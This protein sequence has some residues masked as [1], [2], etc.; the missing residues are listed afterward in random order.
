MIN[1]LQEWQPFYYD[2][3][4]SKKQ[5]CLMQKNRQNYSS[6]VNTWFAS[7]PKVPKSPAEKFEKY[8]VALAGH[9]S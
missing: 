8:K 2:K 1:D 3:A 6:N 9:F 4:L 5:L 7:T